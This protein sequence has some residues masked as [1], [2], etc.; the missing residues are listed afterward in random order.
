MTAT[1]KTE[2]MENLPLI[3][4]LPPEILAQVFH[5]LDHPA[6]SDE[7]LHD[8][9]HADMLRRQEIDSDKANILK[10]VSKV[11]RRWRTT[12]LPLLF[13]NAVWYLD[14]FDLMQAEE[15]SKASSPA[16]AIPMLP[17]L[18]ENNLTS[19]VKSFTLVFIV[20]PPSS[21]PS[22]SR[23]G[24]GGGAT[25]TNSSE[26][27]D[28]GLYRRG[29][30]SGHYGYLPSPLSPSIGG[31]AR[32]LT[33][34]EDTNWLW[35]LIF[36]VVDPLRFT[37]IASPCMLASLL[38]RMLFLGDAWS[39]DQSHHVLSLSRRVEDSR[40][41]RWMD[42]DLKSGRRRSSGEGLNGDDGDV[43]A[44][45]NSLTQ[46]EASPS[47]STSSSRPASS[48]TPSSSNSSLIRPT[49][50]IP[51]DLFSPPP[52]QSSH[53]YPPWTS[54]LLNE[55]SSTRVYKTY[56]YFH[57]RPPSMLGALLGVEEYPND[58]PLLPATNTIA[59][60]SY[61][62]I[63][64]LS[65]HFITLVQHLP[66]LERL[67]VQLVPRNNILN[68]R[69]EM[70]HLDMDDLWSERDRCYEAVVPKLFGDVADPM[71]A[72]S[73]MGN[74]RSLKEF[75]TGDTMDSDVWGMAIKYAAMGFGQWR[76]EGEGRFVK[77]ETLEI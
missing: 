57:K 65:T 39:F 74:W 50:R 58:I 56:E 66:P 63:F 38:A 7:R 64:P 32:D 54:L 68:D 4:S 71:G 15:Q 6:P 14:R 30:G 35:K 51:C 3:E 29:D 53:P 55:G 44:D 61:I 41:G 45:S 11:N 2:K 9:P 13:R 48:S 21:P 10:S 28:V 17:F 52:S 16:A 24:G 69:K 75:E 19:Y 59:E 1:H 70:E 23:A 47:S 40:R 27:S 36:D 26:A 43:S 67:Y 31:G 76:M 22:S 49:K 34:N 46:Q 62:G 37:I 20:R 25:T 42:G 60:I 72:M 8:Q 12:I 5:F 33:F 18:C 73:E 77:R